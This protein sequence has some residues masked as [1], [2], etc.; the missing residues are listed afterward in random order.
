MA[1]AKTRDGD[2]ESAWDNAQARL[3][4]RSLEKR[5]LMDNAI[6]DALEKIGSVQPKTPECAVSL[7]SLI[8]VINSLDNPK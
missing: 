6:D 5:T 7:E 4:P 8:T 2:L 3:R 1:G